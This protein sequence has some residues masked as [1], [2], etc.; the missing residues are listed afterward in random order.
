AYVRQL[1]DWMAVNKLNTL[2]WHLVDDQGWRVEIRKY[3]K[4]TSVS[5]WRYPAT[6]PGAPRLPRTG[7]FYTQAEIRAIVAYAAK[8]GITIVPE[9]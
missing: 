1:I 2:H 6:A 8:R 9:I 7:G 4:L 5:G 3:P